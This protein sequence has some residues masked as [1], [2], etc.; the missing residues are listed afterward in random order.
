L[1]PAILSYRQNSNKEEK[2]KDYAEALF[3]HSWGVLADMGSSATKKATTRKPA[4]S[5]GM[6]TDPCYCKH[7][8]ADHAAGACAACECPRYLARPCSGCGHAADRHAGKCRERGCRCKDYKPD[9]TAQFL[10]EMGIRSGQW[11]FITT[12]QLTGL[13]RPG[14]ECKVRVWACG[15]LHSIGHRR[16]VATIFEPDKKTGKLIERALRPQDI[17]EKL[18]ALESVPGTDKSMVRKA[19]A[20]LHEA[21][22][23]RPMGKDADGVYRISGK[24]VR[25]GVAIAFYARPRRR[26]DAIWGSNLT[27]K[28][29]EVESN[30]TD[31]D[32]PFAHIEHSVVKSLRAGLRAVP[33]LGV[34]FDPQIF[35]E[36]LAAAED[37]VRLVV[38]SASQNLVLGVRSAALYKEVSMFLSNRD[39]T[40][41][42]SVS[43]SEISQR[44]APAKTDGLTPEQAEPIRQAIPVWLLEA[45]QENPS[46][47]LLLQIHRTLQGA[48]PELLTE[49]IKLRRKKITSLGMLIPLAADVAKAQTKVRAMTEEGPKVRCST[50]GGWGEIDG[51]PC[52]T[53]KGAKVMSAGA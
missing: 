44:T 20:E 5:E 49:R 26:S 15:M 6:V 39:S 23:C 19:I 46:E 22:L 4:R 31:A 25:F 11:Q 50:C 1:L 13:M 48:P 40:A 28:C 24:R 51:R 14:I 9:D 32:D 41:Q 29:S 21:G 47:G 52:P 18:R 10:L 45:L 2:A 43:Q 30:Q 3:P 12:D 35:Q 16:R 33:D 27:P 34:K 37:L 42:Q 8:K 7:A 36:E 38:K 53:C 17:V